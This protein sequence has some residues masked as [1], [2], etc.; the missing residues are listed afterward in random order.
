MST[1]TPASAPQY[2]NAPQPEPIPEAPK[3]PSVMSRILRAVLALVVAGAVIY[4]FNYFTSDAA[5]SE[6]GDCASVT[7]TTAKPELAVVDCGA[8]EAN[9]TIGKVLGSATESCRGDYNEY[10]ETNRRGPDSKLCLIPKLVEGS[11]YDPAT[12]GV[13]FAAVDCTKSGVVKVV[14]HL[15]GTMDEAACGE[16]EPWVFPEPKLTVCFGAPDSA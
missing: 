12:T 8:A 4:G 11:C 15:P 9:Y 6:A 16:D 7:G 14:K 10:T 3:K 13:G 1:D 2:Q 5:Q